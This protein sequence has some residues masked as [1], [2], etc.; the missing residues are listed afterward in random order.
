MKQTSNSLTAPLPS[1]QVC[2]TSGSALG[3]LIIDTSTTATFVCDRAK[4]MALSDGVN[5]YPT[6]TSGRSLIGKAQITSL[7]QIRRTVQTARLKEIARMTV[8]RL[9]CPRR[10]DRR[11]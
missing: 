8:R 3:R 1:R 9:G 4:D 10:R 2:N 6:H 5:V 7:R 11:R